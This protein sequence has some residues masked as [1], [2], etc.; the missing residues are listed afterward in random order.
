MKISDAAIT[1]LKLRHPCCDVAA[2][3][4]KLRKKGKKFIGPCPLHSRDPKAKDSTSFECE[5]DR[6]VCA[7][8][9]NGGDVIKLV[10]LYHGLDPR[11]DFLAVVDLLGGVTEPSPERAAELDKERKLRAEQREKEAGE[12]REKERRRAFEIWHAAQAWPGT[13]VEQY[14]REARG[15][16]VQPP[17]APRALRYAPVVAYFDGEETN[18]SGRK[19]PRVIHRGPAMLAPIVDAAGVFRGVHVTWLDLAHPKGK[20]LI[21][22]PETG[23][24]LKSKKSYGS[25]AG[26]Y[27][28]LIEAPALAPDAPAD[29]TGNAGEGIETVLSVWAALT[30]AGR[31]L[32]R[33]WFRSTISLGNLS[34]RSAE[35]VRHPTEKDAGGKRALRVPG[36]LPDLDAKA[37]PV[38]VG[39]ARVVLLGDGD[40]DPFRTRC[41]LHCGSKR[42]EAAGVAALVAM[43]PAGEDF[44]DRARVGDFAGIVGLVDAAAPIADPTAAAE[45]PPPADPAVPGAAAPA[46]AAAPAAQDVEAAVVLTAAALTGD[47]SFLALGELSKIL[48]VAPRRPPKAKP[49]ETYGFSKDDDDAPKPV[50]KKS[51]AGAATA[52]ADVAE[53]SETG[54][55]AADAGDGGPSEPRAFGYSVDELNQEFALVLMGSRAV[56]FRE[57]KDAPIEDQKRVL[58]LEAFHAWFLNRFTEYRTADG[59]LKRVTWSK[60]WL[61]ARDRRQYSGIEFSPP[62]DGGESMATPGYLNLWSGFAYTPAETPDPMRYKTFRDHLLN[63]VAGGDQAVFRW[64]FGFFAHIVQRPRERLG[65]ALVL[66]GGQGAGKTIVGGIVGGLFPQHYFLVDDPRYVTGQFNAHMAT[67]LLLQADEAV[68]AGDK[69]AEGRLKGLIT[70]TIQQIEAKG[71]DPIRL[72]NYVRL[73]MTSNED[74]VVPAGKDERRFAVLDVDPRCAQDHAYFAEMTAEMKNGGYEH[75]LGA[76][77]R[78]PLDSVDLRKIPRTAALLEQ[79][80]RSLDS[81]ESWWFARLCAGA[82]LRCLS[83]WKAK[84]PT[85]DLFEDYIAASEKIGIKRKQEETIFGTKLGRLVP[86]LKRARRRMTVDDGHGLKSARVHAALLPDLQTARAEFETVLQQA[87]DWPADDAGDNDDDAVNSRERESDVVPL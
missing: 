16:A 59:T 19:A 4:V 29:L 26:N 49:K 44:N 11:A 82:P 54:A 69:A 9:H 34:G 61:T 13:P 85:N 1:E 68:W 51:A 31:D 39:T 6:W 43:A 53:S 47:R 21:R 77:L 41:A 80:I 5:A 27:I 64:V 10:A 20:A 32:S 37:F 14:L 57:R 84:I 17:L 86:S 70:S 60:A 15:L 2:Q 81:I 55:P 74:W 56:V 50:R 79:K 38:P 67:C 40:S 78:F 33:A 42:L 65:V 66:R 35:S 76:L 72:P 46:D 3:W 58:A 22:D 12:Y 45:A 71:I 73:I 7:V 24:P 83:E 75:L 18:G 23:E 63:N 25:V 30:L 62:G 8:C 28:P 87:I 36:P 48:G 52:A